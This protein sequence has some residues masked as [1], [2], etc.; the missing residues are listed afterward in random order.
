MLTPR[1]MLLVLC[2]FSDKLRISIA[3]GTTF[4]VALVAEGR[5]TT[6]VSQPPLLAGV[7]LGPHFSNGPCRHQFLLTNQGR[8]MQALSWTTEGFSAARKKRA[9]IEH[10]AHDPLDVGKRKK[11]KVGRAG[12]LLS[13]CTCTAEHCIAFCFFPHVLLQ[14]ATAGGRVELPVFSVTPDKIVL[15]PNQ[16]Q[17]ITVEGR[18]HRYSTHV[19]TLCRRH[20]PTY[21]RTDVHTYDTC[22]VCVCVCFMSMLCALM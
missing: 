7:D 22:S 4:T 16:S 14:T 15:C 20:T 8:R 1:H 5:G 19:C 21:I 2:R 17:L 9:E 11:W 6:I 13:C 3:D 10:A 18:C 12:P